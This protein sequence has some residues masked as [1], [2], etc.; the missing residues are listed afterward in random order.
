MFIFLELSKQ[1]LTFQTLNRKRRTYPVDPCLGFYTERTIHLNPQISKIPH[2]KTPHDGSTLLLTDSER[3]SVLSIT[4]QDV[5]DRQNSSL[6]QNSSSPSPVV[7]VEAFLRES[8]AKSPKTYRKCMRSDRECAAPITS[9]RDDQGS[10]MEMPTTVLLTHT[11]QRST[12]VGPV[13]TQSFVSGVKRATAIPSRITSRHATAVRLPYIDAIQEVRH[14]SRSS[15][16][17]GSRLPLNLGPILDLD[18]PLF[19]KSR[20]PRQWKHLRPQDIDFPRPLSLCDRSIA[21]VTTAAIVGYKPM[22]HWRTKE[23]LRANR[24]PT[25]V[26]KNNCIPSRRGVL[27]LK[28]VS[29][30]E[31]EEGL[32]DLK[33]CRLGYMNESCG[34]TS[35]HQVEDDNNTRSKFSRE[36]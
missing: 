30:E 26:P 24:S 2:A 34:A 25:T 12:L 1:F 4:P 8:W 28:F 27:P 31:H 22:T 7:T 11:S 5:D 14:P 21:A 33:A 9:A 3:A 17:V 15:V 6:T 23:L 35:Y 20:K 19:P 10:E 32:F 36:E 18:F 13:D 16:E 29:W